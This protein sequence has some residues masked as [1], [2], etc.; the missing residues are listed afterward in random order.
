MA[1][2]LRAV[3]IG[4]S[5][6]GKH[7]VKWL[8]RAGCEVLGFM[9]T[10]PESVSRTAEMLR[11]MCGFTGQGFTSLSELIG[12]CRPQL[13]S[14]CSPI[15]VHYDHVAACLGS[16]A[17]TLCEKPLVGGEE[18][19]ND[20][21]LYLGGRLVE[22]A[23]KC[24]LF[25]GVNTQ[26]AAAAPHLQAICEKASLGA[27]P[28]TEFFM[29]MESRGEG[30]ARQYEAIWHDLAPH[31]LSVLLALVPDGEVDWSSA[32]CVIEK[33]RNECTFDFMPPDGPVCRARLLLRT[34]PEGP[35]TRQFALNGVDVE[36][37]G[38]NDEDGVYC[39]YLRH[40]GAE[41]KQQDFM[42][43]SIT[44]FAAAASGQGEILADGRMGLRNLEL[45]LRLLEYAVRR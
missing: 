40:E 30:G 20:V 27:S 5:G 29:Q 8:M 3:V 38:R 31:P 10:S 39:A 17:H 1:D 16:G 35:M 33:H 43:A 13:A 9:G 6:I 7:H 2:P 12:E 15:G 18:R 21:Q 44:R 23:D 19:S 34:V 28:A 32:I 4:A 11:E 25:L 22:L 26:Y 36:Y 14:V 24:G 45:Q 37:E 41:L 42:E